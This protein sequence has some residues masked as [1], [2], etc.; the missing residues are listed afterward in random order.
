MHQCG[1]VPHDSAELRKFIA[2]TIVMGLVL[3]HLVCSLA[4]H[5]WSLLTS[6]PCSLLTPHPSSLLTSS[7]PCYLPLHHNHVPPL[8]HN[9]ALSLEDALPD[10]WTLRSGDGA[11]RLTSGWPSKARNPL[12]RLGLS[13]SKQYP[14][15]PQGCSVISEDPWI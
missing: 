7:H 1:K 9:C 10:G 15:R 5:P 8:H 4:S 2:T 6:Y 12:C 14:L 3:Y 13:T 11:E